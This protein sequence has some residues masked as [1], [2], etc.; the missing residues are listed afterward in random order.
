VTIAVL[1]DSASV[2]SQPRA[3]GDAK[4]VSARRG[5]VSAISELHQSGS[6]KLLF[7]RRRGPSLDAV[8][9]NTSGG[10]TGGDRLRLEA[11]AGYGTHVMLTTQAAERA[12]RAQ[13]GA[14]GSVTTAL[15]VEPQSRLDWLPQETILFDGSDLVR[16]TDIDLAP[17]SHLMFCETLV[18]GRTAMGERLRNA[19]LTDRITLTR[20]GALLFADRT[21]LQGDIE[22]QLG[23]VACARIGTGAAGA[24]AT[25]IL[26]HPNAEAALPCIADALP[27]QAGIGLIREG[28]VF[29][30]ILAED[31]FALRSHV[32]PLLRA[33]GTTLP[34]TWTI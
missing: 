12:Y 16:R 13:P 31:G 2:S 27:R 32:L 4:L 18:F 14:R 7:P 20:D 17:D 1:A 25:L 10:I 22:T 21:M 34:R 33:L 6:M 5:A 9:L 8:I 23:R 28:L 29:G 26:A 11:K 24:M 19:R 15:R 30:R 3:R